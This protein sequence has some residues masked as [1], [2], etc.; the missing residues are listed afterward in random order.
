MVDDTDQ[1]QFADRLISTTAAEWSVLSYLLASE[2]TKVTLP[3]G[4]VTT[5]TVVYIYADDDINVYLN[6]GLVA[7]PVGSV[8]LLT[9][10]AITSIQVTGGATL[11]YFVAGA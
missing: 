2:V 3:M 8:L 7:I 4:G 1:S 11:W 6:S 5:A 9:D 10:T